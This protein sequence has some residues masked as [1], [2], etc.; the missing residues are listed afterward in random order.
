[1]QQSSEKHSMDKTVFAEHLAKAY[2]HLYDLVDLRSQ[3]LLSILAPDP[4]LS[5]KEKAWKMHHILLDV[6]SELKPESQADAFARQRRRYNLMMLRYVKG[7]DPSA[8]AEQLL[9]SRR[10]Y[11]REHNI[12][13]EI[14]AD[15]LW[16]RYM[17]LNTSTEAPSRSNTEEDLA[18]LSRMELFRLETARLATA[19]RHARIKGVVAG[20]L[21]LLQNILEK[22]E[23]TLDFVVPNSFPSAAVA[24][25]F[26]KQ[27]LLSVL[28][29][30]IGNVH[31]ARIEGA[32]IIEDGAI[33]L[34]LNTV[35]DTAIRA[36]SGMD[37]QERLTMLSEFGSISGARIRPFYAGTTVKGFDIELPI[38]QRTVLVIDDNR[39]ILELF[40][41][42]LSV[43]HYHVVTVQDAEEALPLA[44]KIHP[45]AITVDLMMPG[46]DGWDL[47]QTLLNHPETEDVPIIVC[48]V[49]K[50]KELALSL[51]A[52]A[53]L[54]KPITEQSL[55]SVLG[56]LEED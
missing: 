23:N 16:H 50:Q 22:H 5:R 36:E 56:A 38:A 40:S 17:M 11:Y 15:I 52:T 43:N 18:E 54:E 12:A 33:H 21:P 26:L 2:A 45:Y 30:L 44:R 9:I 46:Q 27:I 1:M 7:L 55:L 10:H 49:L 48:S 47:L 42:Y 6:I 39:D 14:I 51:G 4:A 29:F 3:P 13:I 31:Q 19:N 25:H 28:S 35:P 24:P 53:F 8:V 37:V 41:R 34:W 32:A 20:V